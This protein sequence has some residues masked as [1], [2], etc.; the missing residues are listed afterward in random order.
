MK[1]TEP[2][3]P[4]NHNKVVVGDHEIKLTLDTETNE[5][6]IV[7]PAMFSTPVVEFTELMRVLNKLAEHSSR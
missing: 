4:V 6:S 2:I 5:L 1:L 3:T 7:T